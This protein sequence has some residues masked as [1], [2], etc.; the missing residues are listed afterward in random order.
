M[1]AVIA[2]GQGVKVPS[3]DRLWYQVSRGQ[4]RHPSIEEVC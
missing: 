2:V 4:T 3:P 1:I